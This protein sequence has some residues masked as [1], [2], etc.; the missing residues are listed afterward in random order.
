MMATF[1]I[2]KGLFGK[3][4]EMKDLGEIKIIIGWQIT[5]DLATRMMKI[6]PS[7]FI[8]DLVIKEGFTD[9]NA[10]VI[11]MKAGSAIEM[12]NP[13]DYEETKLREY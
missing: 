4:Y 2:L 9:C 7:A 11:L 1:K 6:D 13:E 10:N 5:K 12:T 8:R 3:K